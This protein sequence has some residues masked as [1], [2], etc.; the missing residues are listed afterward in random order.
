M[1]L[2]L[3]VSPALLSPA[4]AQQP[5]GGTPAAPLE[6]EVATIR[7]HPAG[8]R[9]TMIGGQPGRYRA[10]NVTLRMLIEQAFDLPAD[11]VSGGPPWMESQRFDVLAK[12]SD[13][14]WQAM[15]KVDYYH[16]ELET[17]QLLQSLLKDRFQLAISHQ[18]KELQVYALVQ[19][20]GGAKVPL[21]GTARPSQQGLSGNFVMGMTTKDA[22]LAE[23]TDFLSGYL[24]RTVLDQTG[25]SGQY[26]ITFMVPE[27]EQN[28]PGESDSA[29]FRA[30]ED[31]LGLKLESRKAVVDTI[32]VQRL[33]QP[34]EN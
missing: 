23:F 17:R 13:A 8:D 25:L 11:Q 3:G 10:T 24:R 21:A 26:D 19:A 27:P 1:I 15:Q 29:V 12:I 14:E 4:L 31:Q 20:R 6:F 16:Q 34:T 32:V 9:T 22:P 33:E 18:P 5:A 7:P 2:A 30:L 28:A